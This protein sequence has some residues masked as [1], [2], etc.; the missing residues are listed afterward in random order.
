MLLSS[1][2]SREKSHCGIICDL[3]WSTEHSRNDNCNC[4]KSRNDNVKL[5]L[6]TSVVLPLPLLKVL[7]ELV[8]TMWGSPGKLVERSTWTPSYKAGWNA[9][10]VRLLEPP[11]RTRTPTSSTWNR[12]IQPTHKATQITMV[13]K[14]HHSVW[15]GLPY[16]AVNNWLKKLTHSKPLINVNCYYTISYSKCLGPGMF[17]I[18]D[19]FQ[20]W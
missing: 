8:T 10:H 6:R 3:L 13:V 17:Q 16:K 19:I 1:P 12:S 2:H 9:M 5:G 18:L 20:I 14:S 11:S 4:G 7:L 15:S